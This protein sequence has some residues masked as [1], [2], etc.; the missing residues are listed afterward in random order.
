MKEVKKKLGAPFKD[1]RERRVTLS[2]R[3]KGSTREKLD[4]L[5]ADHGGSIGKT[6]DFILDS[7]QK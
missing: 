6:I 3:I 4:R 2:T 1:P 5:K 7:F